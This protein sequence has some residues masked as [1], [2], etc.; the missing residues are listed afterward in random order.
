MNTSLATFVTQP[1]VHPGS[2]RQNMATMLDYIQ[3]AIAAN[4]DMIVFPEM[5]IPGYLIGDRWEQD[6]FLRECE[7][8]GEQIRKN[9]R[10]ITIVFGNVAIDWQRH[11]EDG[12]VRKYNA[13][14]VADQE[15]F[16]PPRG[17]DLPF[18]I[19]TLMPNYRQFDD[20][21]HFFDLRKRAAEKGKP[22]ENYL[23]PIDTRHATIG[24]VLCEDAWNQDYALSPLEYLSHH[25]EIQLLIN[26][27][28]SPFTL[29]KNHKRN[30][31]FALHAQQWK[32]PLIYSNITGI[33]NNGKTI[34]TFDGSACVYDTQGNRIDIGT[35]FEPCA[36][37]INIPLNPAIP[38]APESTLQDDRISHVADALIYGIR[39]FLEQTR[40]ERIVIGASGGIDSAVCAALMRCVLP[41]ENIL[42]ANMPSQYNSQTTRSAAAQLAQNLGVQSV[43][44]PIENS[45]DLTISQIEGLMPEAP[46]GIN[47]HALHLSP[48]A[49]ENIQARDRSSRI[50]AALAS[51]FGGAFTCNANK[52]EMTVGYTTLYGDLGGC[53]AP[54]A[55]L[56]KTLV[57]ELAAEL[58]QR[59]FETPVIPQS[60]IDV[61]PSAELS[62]EQ[63]VDQNRG[64]PLIYPYHDRLFASWVER[65]QR[66][67]PEEI[68]EWYAEKSLEEH[69]Q[70]SVQL[71][72]LFATPAE[73]IA[74]LERWWNLYQ[75]MGLA[76]R[77]QA[78]P[79][80]AVTRRAFGFDHREAQLPAFY[81]HRYQ[82]LK[83]QL[84]K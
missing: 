46:P 31:V 44:L 73:F 20:S 36:K 23:T 68:L 58:N 26:A 33:Q 67:T 66:I 22:I 52:S 39:L 12:R 16:I 29:N 64:D 48:L 56:W 38:F 7:A 42:L 78:P 77:I 53:L 50:L 57:Y 4:A 62:S 14:F 19:K 9:S 45:A 8:C 13:V 35:P 11:N 37:C 43:I 74:D 65:W 54:L 30:R 34:Y 27:S 59:F 21:R 5:M 17:S 63:D 3:Q 84:L 15:R 1:I 55:D 60:S 28:A 76:K 79:V 71:N 61:V 32:R 24:C 83:A 41:P 82:S 80:L 25:P 6:A 49:R 47:A 69:I 2:P 75:G 51:A 81:S 70:C 72:H 10:D 40:I 18:V